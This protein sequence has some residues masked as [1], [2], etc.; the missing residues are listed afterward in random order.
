MDTLLDTRK[1][2]SRENRIIDHIIRNLRADNNRQYIEQKFIELILNNEK[3]VS[4]CN[5]NS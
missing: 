3:K 1:L 4:G 5:S 2:L